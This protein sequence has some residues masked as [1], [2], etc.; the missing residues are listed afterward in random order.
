MASP[1]QIQALVDT[2]S[3]SFSEALGENL[4]SCVMYAEDVRRDVTPDLKDLS[5]FIVL[6][7]S[8]PGAHATIADA[9]SGRI[10]FEPFVVTKTEIQKSLKTFALRFRNISRRYTV[11]AGVDPFETIEIDPET[12]QF[13]TDHSRR[14]LLLRAARPAPPISEDDIRQIDTP[15]VDDNDGWGISRLRAEGIAPSPIAE[16]FARIRRGDYVDIDGLL[17]ARNG[18]LVAE[19]YFGGFERLSLHQTRSSFKSA[20][21]LL[22]GIAIADG[23]LAL[24]DPVAPLLARYYEP[25]DMCQWKQRITIRNLL[26]MQSGFDC[27]EMPGTGPFRENESNRS[28]DKVAADFDLSM[29]DEPGT[30]WR[31]CSGNTFLLGVALESALAEGG[32]DSLKQYLDDRLMNPLN[33]ANYSIGRTSKGHLPMQGGECMTMRDF[34]KFGQLLISGGD[35]NGRQVVPANWISDTLNQG[36]TTGWSWT[37]SVGDEPLL[38]RS[39][40]YRFNWFQTPMQVKGRDYR[41][42]HSWGNG[43]QFVLAIPELDLLVG[44]TGSNYGEVLIEEQKQIFHMLYTFIL[45]AATCG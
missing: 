15:P 36:T 9:I 14:D 5:I 12:L 39:S 8:T 28:Q 40:E 44:T 16:M 3:S 34:A 1:E 33:I 38:Q 26:Q 24:D 4:Y 22:T 29:V 43:G 7:E 6:N 41:L 18:L 21:G 32:K 27:F 30:T 37:S 23:L 20:T 42:I 13:L 19:A 11:L 45:P 25:R 10:R 2:L 17:I 35:W 31:Y